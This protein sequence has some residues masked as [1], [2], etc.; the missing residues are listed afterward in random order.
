MLSGYTYESQI[1]FEENINY[2]G[3][4]IGISSGVATADDCQL[5]CKQE[6]QC[7]FWTYCTL[8]LCKDNCYLKS[9]KS[10]VIPGPNQISGPKDCPGHKGLFFIPSILI[11][12]SK[13]LLLLQ[14]IFCLGALNLEFNRRNAFNIPFKVL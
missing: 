8:G 9:G 13:K 7:L 10:N 3:N 5:K 12:V 6:E 2:N 11:N 4:D 14:K 1:C